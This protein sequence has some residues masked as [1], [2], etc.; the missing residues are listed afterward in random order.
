MS[1]IVEFDLHGLLAILDPKWAHLFTATETKFSK[2]TRKT[3]KYQ[4]EFC[5]PVEGGIGVGLGALMTLRDMNPMYNFRTRKIHSSLPV[6][7][8]NIPEFE[9]VEYRWYQREAL[10]AISKARMGIIEIPTGGGKSLVIAA[11]AEAAKVSHNVLIVVPTKINQQ[12]ILKAAHKW[13]YRD[14]T[15]LRVQRLLR[16][17]GR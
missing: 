8:M 7:M 15:V 12:E 5:R 2:F 16:W 4:T 6:L 14:S 11:G 9:G 13:R 10:E 3:K 1:Q 17:Y